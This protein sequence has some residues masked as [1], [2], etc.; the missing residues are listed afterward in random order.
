MPSAL[1]SVSPAIERTEA[2]LFAPFDLGKWFVLGFS[3][4]LAD[5]GGGFNFNWRGMKDEL[6]DGI[7]QWIG[8][9]LPLVIALG[10]VLFFAV[11]ALAILFL[12]LSS[13]GA[14]MFLDCVVRNRAEVQEPWRRFRSAGNALF[15]F[16]FQVGLA[17]MLAFLVLGGLLIGVPAWM[18]STNALRLPFA[19]LSLVLGGLLT[20]AALLA[21]LLFFAILHDFV[22]PIMYREGNSPQAALALFRT[23]LLPGQG[24]ALARFYGLKVALG[25][26]AAVIAIVA[27][28]LSCCLGFLPYL[29]SVLT[30]PISV[31]F[32]AYSLD[33][34]KQL[35]PGRDLFAEASAA[36]EA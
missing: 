16:Q 21:I 5:L 1:R 25:F 14:F 15:W 18:F 17:A 20:L 11:L 26:G 3:A 35:D 22:V 24:T 29:S 33:F 32:R 36:G 6:P 30:L 12:W 2:I 31:F 9:H 19:V 8:D 23:T 27:G 28:C 4:F 13:R 10:I 7:H 34:L